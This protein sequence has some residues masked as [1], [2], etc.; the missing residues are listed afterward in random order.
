[1]NTVWNVPFKDWPGFVGRRVR[2]LTILVLLGIGILVS[3]TLIGYAPRFGPLSD[4]W[5]SAA[6]AGVNFLVFLVCFT[7]LTS[8]TVRVRDVAVG[9]GVR[10]CVLGN[11]ATHRGLVRPLHHQPLHRR[12]R[13]LRHRP[14]PA[15]VAVSRRP[16][17]PAR[18]RDQRCT[19]LPALAP[20]D[21]PTPRSPRRTRPRWSDWRRWKNDAPRK[22]STSHLPPKPTVDHSTNQARP[23]P[24]PTDPS[25]PLPEHPTEHRHPERYPG[26]HQLGWW[27][28]G[29]ATRSDD[30]H[31]HLCDKSSYRTVPKPSPASDTSSPS[32]SFGADEV[33]KQIGEEFVG[34][35][36]D[37]G[38]DVGD[39]LKVGVGVSAGGDA[40]V[41]V[42]WSSST[43]TTSGSGAFS[44]DGV[45]G[46]LP[47]KTSSGRALRARDRR[48]ASLNPPRQ[49]H[50]IV[51]AKDESSQ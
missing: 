16:A 13:I 42:A 48:H 27:S 34:F 24:P 50:S 43:S 4:A 31:S 12:V 28:T 38:E 40:A 35:V 47:G 8:A 33:R 5:A 10:H 46:G 21:D 17:D 44:C 39:I 45:E 15:V 26:H 30:R 23:N 22:P 1:M 14:G 6:A 51:W 20:I 32:T 3:T 29:K 7:V 2:G 37:A 49:Y 11:P 41:V 19:A 36:F 9:G 25:D 18:R